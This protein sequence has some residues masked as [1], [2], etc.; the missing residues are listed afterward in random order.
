MDGQ[1]VSLPTPTVPIDGMWFRSA[2]QPPRATAMLC[3]GNGANFYSGPVRFL[4]SHLVPRGIECFSFNRRG[5]ETLTSRTRVPEGNAYQTAAEAIEDNEIARAHVVQRAGGEPVV[6]GHSNGGLFAARHVADHPGVR[7]LVLLSAHLGGP[8]M[9]RRGSEIGL[10]AQ[11]R[12]TE[13][14]AEAHR[15]VES[16]EP[17][18]LLLMPGWWYVVS[19]A[20]YLDM[21]SDNIPRIVEAAPRIE[22]PVLYL[23]GELEDPEMYPAENFAAAGHAP[24]DVRIVSG[25]D[26]FYSGCEDEVGRMVGDWLDTI[27]GEPGAGLSGLPHD[28]KRAGPPRTP[29]GS[30]PGARSR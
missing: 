27:L 13:I 8:E 28:V 7:A 29:P 30:A 1:L 16:G 2:T 26:H 6:I 14:S 21:E 5:H 11:G 20:T 18:A 15:L 3:H 17:E 24:V 22:C 4:S 12:R 9:L 10:M 25:A 19:A 23:R